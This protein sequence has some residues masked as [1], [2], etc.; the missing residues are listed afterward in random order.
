MLAR[1]CLYR[2]LRAAC[3]ATT[4]KL[5]KLPARGRLLI[6]ADI[7]GNLRDFLS[8][9]AAFER[10]LHLSR[11]DFDSGEVFLLFL[12]DLLHGPY[13]PLEAWAAQ[14]SDAGYLRGR[15][16]RDQSPAILF[17]LSELV[18]RYP[19]RVFC[20]LGN[21]EHAHIGGPRTSRFA[22]DEA[23]ALEQRLGSEVSQWLGS[24]LRN[25]PLWA[26]APCGLLFSHAAPA[27]DLARPEDLETL[28]YR[29]YTPPKKSSCSIAPSSEIVE[30]RKGPPPP[31]TAARLLGQLLWNH[32]LSP[33]Q[34]QKLLSRINARIAVYGHTVIPAGYQTIGAEQLILSSS[35]GM[36]DACKRILCID[37]HEQYQ[38]VADLRPGIELLPLYPQCAGMALASPLASR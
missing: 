24:S 35:F 2:R 1:R 16:Y 20:L 31:E 25:L 17:E 28:D 22:R 10:A 14:Q 36:E 12:G 5:L 23:L 37:L 7:H 33:A 29:R 18:A 6:A 13:L 3:M 15:P 38:S 19:G 26:L 21:H 9:V 32:S 34:A 8:V 27:A 11:R 30:V 4:C